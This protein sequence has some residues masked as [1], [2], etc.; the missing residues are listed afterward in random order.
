MWPKKGTPLSWDY[1]TLS[2]PLASSTALSFM[3][4]G[5]AAYTVANLTVNSFKNVGF[6]LKLNLLKVYN[7]LF[8]I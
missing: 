1:N 4:V 6:K 5:Q 3:L 7:L 2:S 8:I